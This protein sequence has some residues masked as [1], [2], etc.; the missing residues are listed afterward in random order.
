MLDAMAAVA[1]AKGHGGYGWT[2]RHLGKGLD[3]VEGEM[4]VTSRI[5]RKR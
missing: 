1:A 3:Y 2:A 5:V 4:M